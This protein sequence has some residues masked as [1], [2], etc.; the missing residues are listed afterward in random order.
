[1]AFSLKSPNRRSGS[2]LRA[3]VKAMA[4]QAPSMERIFRMVQT[5]SVVVELDCNNCSKLASSGTKTFR[6]L[7]PSN[8]PMM[9][10]LCLW[11]SRKGWGVKD[12]VKV[13][14]A[15]LE[16]QLVLT[17][18]RQRKGSGYIGG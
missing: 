11:E 12:G 7:L 6:A 3:G 5:Y 14:G 9:P 1:M 8:G 4:Q 18:R 17:K 10:F 15:T 2:W 13:G 16:S